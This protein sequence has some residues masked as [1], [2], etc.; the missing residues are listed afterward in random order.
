MTKD[1]LVEFAWG[2]ANSKHPFLWV[3]RPDLV[4]GEAAILPPEF[5]NET[6]DRGMIS[7]WCLQEKVLCHSSTGV[8]DTMCGG[9]R[10]ISWPFFG[11]QQTNCW[12]A[13]VH[14]GFGTEIDK[15]V[16]RD[17]VE[18]M[19]RELMESEKGKEMKERAMEWKKS[20]EDSIKPGGS[21]YMNLDKVIQEVLLQKP[22]TS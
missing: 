6:A 9:V 2:L 18:K 12:N 11:D 16:K 1:Q 14:W 5:T 4:I 17:E 20:A 3:I 13:C 7:G 19:L 22:T 15:N 8:M 21:S 10:I